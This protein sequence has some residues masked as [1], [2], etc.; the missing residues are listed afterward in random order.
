MPMMRILVIMIMLKSS[1]P[2]DYHLE[3]TINL[4]SLWIYINIEVSR[5]GWQTGDRLDV[6]CQ[7]VPKS[8]SI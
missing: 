1:V 4:A 3:E 6:S 2:Y 5:G 8:I 7:S